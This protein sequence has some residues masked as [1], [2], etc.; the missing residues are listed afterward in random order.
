MIEFEFQQV[1]VGYMGD[2]ATGQLT[3]LVF[4]RYLS[5]SSKFL[6][7][8]NVLKTFPCGDKARKRSDIELFPYGFSYFGPAI[9]S[10]EVPRFL[11]L[12]IIAYLVVQTYL[13][14][15]CN[16][17]KMGTDLWT[18]GNFSLCKTS[19]I[20]SSLDVFTRCMRRLAVFYGRKTKTNW[21]HGGWLDRTGGCPSWGRLLGFV[22]F[23]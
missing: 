21:H 9:L 3:K 1:H 7:L 19:Y 20:Y 4:D 17:S 6:F 16:S 22:F 13:C 18:G 23:F 5:A 12:P 10:N 14:A 11:L 2:R 8:D 15:W